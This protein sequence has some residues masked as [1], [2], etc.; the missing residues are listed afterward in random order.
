MMYGFVESNFTDSL[1]V[2]RVKKLLT[3][4]SSRVVESVSLVF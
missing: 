2:T 4:A 3:Q 1:V